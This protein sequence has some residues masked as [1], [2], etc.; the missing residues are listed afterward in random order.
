MAAHDAAKAWRKSS[1]G[2]RISYIERL[3]EVLSTANRS[4]AE[5]M[6]RELGKPVRFGQQEALASLEML[7]GIVVRHKQGGDTETRIDYSERRRPH[8]VV[9]AITPWNNPIYLP[10]GKLVPAILHGN[11]VVWKPAPEAQMV[12]R[13]LYECCVAANWP[14]GLVQLV[15]GGE[16]EAVAV[17]N[18]NA[19]GAVTITGSSLTGY[20]A[21]ASAPADACPCKPSLA[22][23]MA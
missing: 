19:V 21:Q 16:R 11:G 17:M 7:N 5:L 14:Q 9:A 8:G 15:E 6:A 20:V 23:T 10:L 4:F 13:Q 2:E 1:A 12:S 18:H 3:A 22:A